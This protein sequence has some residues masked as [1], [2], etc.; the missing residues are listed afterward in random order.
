ME[1]LKERA[2]KENEEAGFADASILSSGE[3]L[4]AAELHPELLQEM[5]APQV[6]D[7]EIKTEVGGNE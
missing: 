7:T 3:N 6:Q 5:A 2:K 1:E 4:E